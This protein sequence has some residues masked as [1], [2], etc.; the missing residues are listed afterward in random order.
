MNENQTPQINNEPKNKEQLI[1]SWV[2][3][4]LIL[5]LVGT[6]IFF[7]WKF[8]E[9]G[10][11]VKQ[12]VESQKAIS[13]QASNQIVSQESST[14][15]NVA[16]NTAVPKVVPAA[17]ASQSSSSTIDINYEVKKMDES[18]NSVD[19]NNFDS[20]DYSNAQIGI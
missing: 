7:F 12:S 4:I 9:T 15:G 16:S 11:S 1:P 5:V 6:F 13:S 18:N 17:P 8:Q 19:E 2:G 20:N 14:A 10:N 3:V